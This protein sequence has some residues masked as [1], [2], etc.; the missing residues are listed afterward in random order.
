VRA[1]VRLLAALLVAASLSGRAHAGSACGALITNTAM[2]TM[3]SGPVD[4][5]GYVLTYAV[6][7]V[8]RVV[9]PVVSMTKYANRNV[10]AV[11]STVTFFI[12]VINDRADSIWN[13]T[14]TDRMPMS[15]GF[16]SWSTGN[17][18][19]TSG[20]PYAINQAWAPTL[21]GVYSTTAPAGGTIGP[22]Y[23]RWR[24][25]RIGP[26]KSACVTY[27]ATVL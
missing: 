5:I 3:W 8:V 14:V 6:T 11:G 21:T 19:I 13:V 12:C 10:A 17:Y 22:L 9:C 23:M 18:N 27:Q 25:E 7:A 16:W 20:G 24:I 1:V 15:M 26:A 4:Q 2:L